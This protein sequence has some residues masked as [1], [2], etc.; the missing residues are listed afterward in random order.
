[1]RF[2]GG[3]TAVSLDKNLRFWQTVLS[4]PLISLVQ[5]AEQASL[6]AVGCDCLATIGTGVFEQLPVIFI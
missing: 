6:R 5:N 2:L 1:M 4:G 3:T